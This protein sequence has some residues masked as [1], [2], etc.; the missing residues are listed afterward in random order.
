M[1]ER[2]VWFVLDLGRV[3]P[4]APPE[5]FELHLASEAEAD[6]LQRPSQHVPADGGPAACP[7]LGVQLWFVLT[8][9]RPASVCFAFLAGQ[10]FPLE[11]TR[12]DD[13]VLPGGVGLP[14]ERARE[15]RV[16]GSSDRASRMDAASPQRLRDDG[17]EV[18]MTRAAESN[19]ASG[20][21]LERTGFPGRAASC[22]AGGAG[23]EA[24]SDSSETTWS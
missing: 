17:Y 5:G 4:I 9:G 12:G 2:F 6:L 11:G 7:R 3:E 8:D 19:V 23:Y 10:R 22:A 18:L 14:R 13:Y 16:P 1:D 21:T 20:R 15:P 24:R